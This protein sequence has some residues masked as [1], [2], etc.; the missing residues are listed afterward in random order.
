MIAEV[1]RVEPGA[2]IGDGTY[3]WHLAHVR[4]GAAVGDNC[5]IGGGAFIDAGVVVGDN[6]KIQNAA[7]VFA[8]ARLGN[9]VFIGPGAILTN[10]RSPRALNEDGEPKT[11]ADWTTE[12]VTVQ[13]GASVGAGAVVV[14]GV[15]I[16]RWAM[17][18]AGAVIT[19]D[20]LDHELVAGVP[21]TNLGWV[22]RN[23]DRLKRHGE[24]W[25]SPDGRLYVTRV[26]GL[27]E[28]EE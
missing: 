14:A 12:P 15:T 24:K 23:G 20:V 18:A 28:V 7:Q 1:A 10:D 13:E 11:S 4:D 9:G 26:T 19:R 21:A 2:T 3:V 22:A 17:V 27:V 6:C 5:V 25:R 8:P 16:G